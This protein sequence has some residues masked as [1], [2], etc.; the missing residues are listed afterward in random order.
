MVWAE[1]QEEG[2]YVR[3][4]DLIDGAV[5]RHKVS[6]GVHVF[7]RV[8]LLTEVVPR[9]GVVRLRNGSVVDLMTAIAVNAETGEQ[10]KLSAREW[11]LFLLML[12]HKN[13]VVLREWLVKDGLKMNFTAHSTNLL[14]V[15][16]N[17]VRKKLGNGSIVTHHS[18]GY[19]LM[20]EEVTE[21]LRDKALLPSA[22]GP[23]SYS[24]R[25]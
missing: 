16:I 25:R 19:Q 1:S 10:G 8:N 12:G 15:W 9:E 4:G 3:L 2:P 14:R 13:K 17:L 20:V 22:R 21:P 6:A 18:I 23:R 5:Y 7:Y 24:Q 11:T